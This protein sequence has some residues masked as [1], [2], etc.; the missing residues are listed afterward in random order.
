MGALHFS[1]VLALPIQGPDESD[2]FFRLAQAIA[3]QN[4][5]QAIASETDVYP[6]GRQTTNIAGLKMKATRSNAIVMAPVPV[7]FWDANIPNSLW[8]SG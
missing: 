4:A 3:L 8:L 2:D 1:A 5:L 7:D 6:N